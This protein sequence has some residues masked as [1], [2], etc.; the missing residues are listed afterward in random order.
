[1]CRHIMEIHNNLLKADLY[2]V[3]NVHEWDNGEG[4]VF[5][6]CVHHTLPTEG[7]YSQKWLRSGSL[8]HTTL[9]KI[10]CNKTLL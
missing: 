5:S 1:M 10:V 8:I 6:K 9:N 7:Q 2:I 4:S 3:R